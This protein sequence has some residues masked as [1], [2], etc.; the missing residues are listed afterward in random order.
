VDV[1]AGLIE[2]LE[3]NQSAIVATI[4]GPAAAPAGLLGRR[5]LVRDDGRTEGSLG[6][7]ALDA[8]AAAAGRSLMVATP[9]ARLYAWPLAPEEGAALGLASAAAVEVFVEAVLPPLT[10]VVVGGG[11]IAQP[12]AQLG[13]ML[14]FRIVVLDD[15]PEFANRERF[16]QADCVIVGPYDVELGRLPIASSTYVVLVTRGHVQDEDALRQVIASPAGYVGMIG[17][18][19]RVRAVL[20]RMAEAGVPQEAIDRVFSPIG[21]DIGAETP[22]EIAVS[23][24]AEVIGVRR[25]GGR[26]PASLSQ[27]ERLQ[28]PGQARH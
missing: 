1:F 13:A 21:L 16:P 11:H 25:R 2:A 6:S 22:E 10:L 17:S 18:R 23:I 5:L 14:G 12:L 26:H 3:A 7:A 27:I 4:V 28:D 19:R 15:R 20:G 9:P 8:R 24:M